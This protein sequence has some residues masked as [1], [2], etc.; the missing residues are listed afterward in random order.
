MALRCA[1]CVGCAQLATERTVSRWVI[2][3]PIC[4]L[5]VC[6][7]CV[8]CLQVHIQ[9]RPQAQRLLQ[10]AQLAGQ[11]S[12]PLGLR[13]RLAGA[14]GQGGL[15]RDQRGLVGWGLLVQVACCVCIVQFAGHM[16]HALV[17]AVGPAVATASCAVGK[18][19][20]CIIVAPHGAAAYPLCSCARCVGAFLA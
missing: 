4:S 7:F 18:C 16:P 5:S 19:G 17:D 13:G 10:A 1:G 15:R 20:W 6:H 11:F 9:P 14:G 12:M 2:K 3:I 8:S